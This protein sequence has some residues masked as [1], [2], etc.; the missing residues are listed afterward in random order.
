VSAAKDFGLTG[1]IY[2]DA[3]GCADI[4]TSNEPSTLKICIPKPFH[5]NEVLR[6]LAGEGPESGTTTRRGFDE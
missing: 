4:S 3:A 1:L 2:R 6:D 5:D